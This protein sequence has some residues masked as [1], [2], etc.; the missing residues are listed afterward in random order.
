ML[1]TKC[2]TTEEI[3][4]DIKG[5]EGL[6]QIS[7]LG[8]VKSFKRK[9]NFIAEYGAVREAERM[10]GIYAYNIIRCCKKIIE[11]EKGFIWRYKGEIK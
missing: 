1:E 5:F 4:K 10:T 6:Y 3:W 2:E 9:G 8:K 7:N 11:Q